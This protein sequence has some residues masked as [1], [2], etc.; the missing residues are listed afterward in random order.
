[1]KK[2]IQLLIIILLIYVGYTGYSIWTYG[3]GNTEANAD[4]AMVL[5]A[6]QWN[7]KPSP[8]FEGRLKQGIE[9]YKEGQV[10]YL[11][12]TG[13]ASEGSVTSEGEA[14]RDYAIEWGIPKKDIIVEDKSMV[15]EENL[16]NAETL[17]EKEKITSILLVSDTFHLKRAVNLAEDK[18]MNAIGVPTKYSAYQSWE[19]K[20][21]FFMQEWL[22]YIADPFIQVFKD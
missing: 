3:Q 9:L 10:D 5:G 4:A 13:G 17:I 20:I 12:V 19:T 8:V 7:G 21:P 14:G 6:A 15:T 18:G 22:Y 1:M 16:S 11:I 2:I